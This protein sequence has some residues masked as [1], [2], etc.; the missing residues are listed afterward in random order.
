MAALG[1]W[2]AMAARPRMS[3]SLTLEGHGHRRE[4]ALT[5]RR[6]TLPENPLGIRGHVAGRRGVTPVRVKL[7]P[8]E[9]PRLKQG[10]V[11]GEPVTMGDATVMWQDERSVLEARLGLRTPG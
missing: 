1:V 3:G 5:G 11:N 4:I 7:V 6:M 10:L 9:G 8:S 2:L